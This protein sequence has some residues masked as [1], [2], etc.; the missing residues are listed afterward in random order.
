LI[1]DYYLV[2]LTF[3]VLKLT[4]LSSKLESILE[5]SR[6][7]FN[8]VPDLAFRDWYSNIESRVLNSVMKPSHD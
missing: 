2:L 5:I 7:E 3:I 6:N 1:I 8:L 4:N